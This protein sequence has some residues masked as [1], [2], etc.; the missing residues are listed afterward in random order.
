MNTIL[1]LGIIQALFLMLLVF[2]K[3]NKSQADF[4]L[5]GML[6]YNALHQFFFIINFND[7]ITAPDFVMILGGGFPLLYGPILYWYVSSLIQPQKV[8]VVQFFIHII[9]YL[10][11][12]FSFFWYHFQVP[13]S[14]VLIFDGFV[15][16]KG[17]FPSIM[18]SYSIF[19]AISAGLYPL[20]CLVLLYKHK[21]DIHHQFSFEDEITLDWLR[22][23]LVFTFVAF[24]VCFIAI[25]LVI[26]WNLVE[27]PRVAFYIVSG[28]N[29]LF[30]FVLGYFGLKQT[31]IFSSV[32][33][34]TPDPKSPRYRRSGLDQG[35]SSSIIDQADQ[36][37]IQEKPWKNPKLNLQALAD[38]IDISTNHLSQSIN[39]NR[40]LN[41]F[42]YVNEFRVEEF[43]KKIQN[44][45]NNHL[46]LLGIAYDCGFNSKSSFNHIF[47][48]KTGF[49]PS[50]Y[51]KQLNL[52]K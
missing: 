4:I 14:E 33:M 48:S 9:P 26:D 3:K 35:K 34:L 42:E 49:T 37:M 32:E 7:E 29:T 38:M 28:I 30:I 25:L 23:L 51:K 47:K 52:T 13:G 15:H 50:V 17:N 5:L 16:L 20:V 43:K 27:N 39:E 22:L 6:I 36:I 40:N 31:M 41:F 24:I 8:K 1:I 18:Y 46:T 2:N 45:Q 44:P 19:Y 21:R 11:F 10:A 12:E